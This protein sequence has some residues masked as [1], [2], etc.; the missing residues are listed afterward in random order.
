M[1][2]PTAAG[3]AFIKVAALVGA[4]LVGIAAL[5]YTAHLFLSTAEATAAGA[6]AIRFPDDPFVDWLV[7]GLQLLL[8]TGLWI[9]AALAATGFGR[10]GSRSALVSGGLLWLLF[11]VSLL[12]SLA[13]GSRWVVL[14]P[15]AVALAGRRPMTMVVFYFTSAPVQAVA[16]AAVVLLLFD[17]RDWTLP[18]AGMA[19]A[20]AVLVYARLFGRLAQLLRETDELRAAP[21]AKAKARP[22]RPRRIRGR[23]RDPWAVP[24]DIQPRELPAVETAEGPQHG[25]DVRFDDSPARADV[26]PS[27]RPFDYD[28]NPYDLGGEAPAARPI[29]QEIAEPS[30]REMALAVRRRSAAPAW[31]WT[32]GTFTFP[33][34]PMTVVAWVILSASWAATGFM[35]RLFL[36]G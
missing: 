9:F 12:S 16:V 29:P 28:P 14:S 10:D 22:K 30:E 27:Q 18:L 17:G 36:S 33:F 20:A 11:P 32:D 8:L 24:H 23:V 21:V 4:V 1:L 19:F 35:V 25:Y 7:G 2:D 26:A 34:Y 15:R 5:A 3:P 31:P 6:D 13:S